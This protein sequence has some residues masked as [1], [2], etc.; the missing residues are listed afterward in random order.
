VLIPLYQSGPMW[1][2]TV[3]PRSTLTRLTRQISFES[4]Y[5]VTFQGRKTN[6]GK[7]L[8]FEGLL[9]LAPFTDKGHIWYAR[10]DP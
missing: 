4:V 10:V 2:E 9:Y 3:D 5:C 8:T 7:I 6:L 1:Q